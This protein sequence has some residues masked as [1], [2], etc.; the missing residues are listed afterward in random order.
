VPSSLYMDV[1]VPVAI[2]TGLRL[3]G[4][5]VLTSQEDQS[6]E[7]SDEALL[8]RSTALNRVLF[9]QDQDFLLIAADLQRVGVKF[10]AIVYAHQLGPGIGEIV[11]DLELLMKAAEDE[12]LWNRV[13]HLPLR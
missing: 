6:I 9:T 10:R 11:G 3:R 13:I 8:K 4:I 1:H 7:Y 2:T 12:E 5:D